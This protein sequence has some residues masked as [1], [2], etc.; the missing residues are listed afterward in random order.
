M[1]VLD[2]PS[3]YNL[4]LYIFHHWRGRESVNCCALKQ[5]PFYQVGHTSSDTLSALNLATF[6]VFENSN[7]FFLI[8]QRKLKSVK[9]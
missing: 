8:Y 3:G 6:L 1:R 4:N 5:T 9:T 2:K 7:K